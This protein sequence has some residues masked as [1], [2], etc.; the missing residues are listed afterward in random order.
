V[1]FA[2]YLCVI[3]LHEYVF[4]TKIVATV[5]EASSSDVYEK[6]PNIPLRSLKRDEIPRFGWL[7]ISVLPILQLQRGG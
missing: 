3:L 1:R 6:N 4:T 5:S 7:V 2:F